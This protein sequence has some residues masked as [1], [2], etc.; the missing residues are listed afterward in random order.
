VW[1][2][3]QRLPSVPSMA[4]SE[5]TLQA[6]LTRLQSELASCQ[7][8]A[9]RPRASTDVD[10]HN[11][12]RELKRRKFTYLATESELRLL[13]T[14]YQPELSYSEKSKDREGARV[15]AK[16]VLRELKREVEREN[17]AKQ[18]LYSEI[19]RLAAAHG[20]A[21]DRCAHDLREAQ[22]LH[23]FMQDE[24]KDAQEVS[25]SLL[26]AGM[27]LEVPP[28]DDACALTEG[29]QNLTGLVAAQVEEEARQR[30]HKFEAD[31]LRKSLK[32]TE[33][34]RLELER[35]EQDACAKVAELQSKAS[36]VEE[37]GLGLPS[38]TFD[39]AAGTVTLAWPPCMPV[40]SG[41]DVAVRTVSVD[42]DEQ[43]AL[44]RAHPHPSLELWAEARHSVETDDLARLLTLAWDRICQQA[45]GSLKPGISDAPPPAA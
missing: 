29:V 24:E 3:L 18:D 28:H 38:I 23:A 45:E 15:E 35:L 41:D 32:D 44:V 20:E 12:C 26:P 37:F 6:R 27:E 31:C 2:K 43:G 30:R 40:P 1:F 17:E 36:L 5:L 14:C 4:Q 13:Q 10:F 39:D 22:Q 25:G 9:P 8:D 16:K 34:V 21:H 33:A 11:A 42:F 7:P 19:S